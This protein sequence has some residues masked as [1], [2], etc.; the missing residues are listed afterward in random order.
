MAKPAAYVY[1]STYEKPLDIRPVTLEAASQWAHPYY[2]GDGV[3]YAVDDS[4]VFSWK[5]VVEAPK[6]Y[7][8]PRTRDFTY[9]TAVEW[10]VSQ[11][12]ATPGKV[13]EDLAQSTSEYTRTNVAQHPNATSLALTRAAVGTPRPILAK[14]IAGRENVSRETLGKLLRMGYYRVA[15]VVLKNPKLGEKDL[16][17]A[18]NNLTGKKLI[19]YQGN[20]KYP[21]MRDNIMRAVLAHPNVSMQNHPPVP[22]LLHAR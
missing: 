12:K 21:E 1:R 6:F 4:G 20:M 3:V 7:G 19:D 11:R 17:W 13:L 16:E 9:L 2:A 15:L 14:I 18:T 10:D 8:F 22:R 5:G